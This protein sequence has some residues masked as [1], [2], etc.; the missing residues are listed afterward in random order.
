M[1]LNVGCFTAALNALEERAEALRGTNKGR[2]AIIGQSHG[3]TL[4]RALAARRPTSSRASCDGLAAR[5]PVCHPPCGPPPRAGRERPRKAW[6]HRACS[7]GTA[8]RANAAPRCAAPRA[9]VP[10]LG[11]LRLRVLPYRCHRGLATPASTPRPSTWRSRPA[12]SAWRSTPR[13]TG[14]SAQPWSGSTPALSRRRR[15]PSALNGL[16]AGSG[17]ALEQGD[18]LDVRR[19]REHVDGRTR[20]SVHPPRRVGPRGRQRRGLQETYTMRRG[21]ASMTR[22]TTFFD[23]PARGG[24]TTRTSGRPARSTSSRSAS[25]TSPAKKCACSTSL[26]RA[27]S[28]ASATAE[29]DD[30]EPPQLARAGGQRQPDRAD[31][32]VEV[33]HLLPTAQAGVLGGDRVQPLGHLRVRLE[34]LRRGRS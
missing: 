8:W 31:A 20:R 9:A 28:I 21:A 24:S 32:A 25:R 27:F 26:R 2:V 6:A 29:L 5:R 34:E 10:A 12:T 4:G 16:N 33:E 1:R 23:S 30:L 7:A 3:G 18:A 19:L 22:R 15:R 11:R 13:P 14:R 17:V